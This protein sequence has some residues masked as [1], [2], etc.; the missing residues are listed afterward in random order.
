M[1]N[2]YRTTSVSFLT[3]FVMSAMLAPIGIISTPM[4]EYFDQPVTDVTRQFSWL[5]GGILVGAVIALFIYDLV[6][7]KHVLI[8]VY[9]LMGL[10]LISFL[11][12][13]SLAV[14]SLILGLVG[15][16]CGIGLAGAALTISRT[17]DDA[18]RASMLVITDSCFSVAGFLTAWI[19]TWFI[20]REFGWSS[21]YQL[22]GLVAL[23]ICAL[24]VSASF[25]DT[26]KDAEELP[27]LEPWPMPVWLAVVSLFLYTLGQYSML[28]WLP[29]YASTYLSASTPVAGSLVGQFWVGMF[30]AQLFVAWWV[31]KIG[32]RKLVLL[33]AV[34]TFFGSLALWNYPEVE[35]LVIITL[36]WGFLNLGMLKALISF[37]TEQVRLPSARLVSLLLLGA[38][39]GTAL[40]PAVT[41]QIVDW[42]D[43]QTVLIFGSGCYGTLMLLMLLALYLSRGGQGHRQQPD[44]AFSQ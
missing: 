25:P 10:L 12:V 23:A 3:Y 35:G 39:V 16:G 7:L 1:K 28:F 13:P 33:G 36:L 24:S 11:L 29:S 4:A 42:T 18:K 6:R 2:L 38:T 37:A 21:T 41:S 15:T 9:G 14:S 22:V 32:V 19:A 30:F 43:S 40:S 44:Q 8:G 31:L 5:T 17:F 34:T 26:V 20:S 27:V